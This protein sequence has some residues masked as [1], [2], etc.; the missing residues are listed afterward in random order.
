MKK[1]LMLF[2]VFV[3]MNAL[4]IDCNDNFDCPDGMICKIDWRNG[5]FQCVEIGRT[6]IMYDSFTVTI[7]KDE[8]DDHSLENIR[9]LLTSMAQEHCLQIPTD[10][11]SRFYFAEAESIVYELGN[12]YAQKFKCVLR[13]V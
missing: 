7:R 9:G 6:K 12:T 13:K 4:A 11:F 3:S 10:S 2:L 5:P 1:I 8:V